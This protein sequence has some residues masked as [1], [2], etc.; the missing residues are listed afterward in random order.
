[1]ICQISELLLNLS[2]LTFH[3]CL[4]TSNPIHSTKC[5]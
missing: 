2:F 5:P 1:V 4:L 3:L